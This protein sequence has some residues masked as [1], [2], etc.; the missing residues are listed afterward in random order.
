LRL[1]PEPSCTLSALPCTTCARPRAPPFL[2]CSDLA[3]FKAFFNGTRDWADLA[4]II[5]MRA[6]NVDQ[7]IGVLV[8]Y[9]GGDDERVER[10]HRLTA[11]AG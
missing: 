9:L 7:T 2:E 10:L 5:A 3:V 11:S 4:E 8:R 6:L 1:V